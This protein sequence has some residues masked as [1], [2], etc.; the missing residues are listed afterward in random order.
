MEH[1]GLQANDRE[2]V[3]NIAGVHTD[4]G[5]NCNENAGSHFIDIIPLT[6]RTIGGSSIEGG[7]GIYLFIYPFSKKIKKGSSSAGNLI[8][9]SVICQ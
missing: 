5:R 4:S 1:E 2:D 9:M 7:D 6:L 8:R 3:T